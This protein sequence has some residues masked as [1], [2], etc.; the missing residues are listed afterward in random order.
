[1]DPAFG[2]KMPTTCAFGPPEGGHAPAGSGANKSKEQA[3][4]EQAQQSGGEAAER[5]EPDRGAR[6]HGQ[7]IAPC[8]GLAQTR[9]VSSD[10]TTTPGGGAAIEPELE[11]ILRRVLEAPDLVLRRDLSAADVPG[12]DSIRMA[13]IVLDVEDHFGVR[14]AAA[15]LATLNEIG[16]LIDAIAD[17]RAAGGAQS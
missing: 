15:R 12:W 17:A 14:L 4:P 13:D 8:G 9:P 3:D 5:A 6:N 11:A 16:D 7:L 1:M 10:E 2:Q